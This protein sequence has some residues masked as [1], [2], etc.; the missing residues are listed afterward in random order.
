MSFD[1]N[2]A[3]QSRLGWFW[4]GIMGMAF[5]AAVGLLDFLACGRS[6][7]CPLNA[8]LARIES[9]FEALVQ[10]IGRA[11]GARYGYVPYFP[12]QA[13]QVFLHILALTLPWLSSFLLGIIAYL[14][15]RAVRGR[16]GSQSKYLEKS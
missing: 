1:R 9:V 7:Y 12:N 6:S 16:V 15:V 4:Y 8:F 11:L 14:I 2:Q 13:T 3:T 10:H 5:L